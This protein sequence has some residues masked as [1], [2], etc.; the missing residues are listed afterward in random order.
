M[1]MI[2]SNTSKTIALVKQISRNPILSAFYEAGYI[3]YP[4]LYQQ[5]DFTADGNGDNLP[6]DRDNPIPDDIAGI[7]ESEA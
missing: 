2:N 5:W 7:M 6:D 3:D 4:T 1:I